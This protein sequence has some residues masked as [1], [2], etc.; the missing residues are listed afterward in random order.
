MENFLLDVNVWLALSD[1]G[2]SHHQQAWAWSQKLEG[3]YR[4][5]MVRHTQLAMLRLLTS[6]AAMGDMVLNLREGW[7]VI[8]RWMADPHVEFSPEPAGLERSFRRLTLDFPRNAGAKVIAD[9]YL[10][11]FADE[12]QATLAT[13]DRALLRF[14]DRH[15]YAA[16]L[17]A[18]M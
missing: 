16:L 5:L 8:D 18:P 15:Q 13:F 4:L 3:E 1:E 9:C 11:A 6:E 14:A 2:H 12:V 17:P 10:L 7:R